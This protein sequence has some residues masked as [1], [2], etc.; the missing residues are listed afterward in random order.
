[1]DV[2]IL[3]PM[4]ISVR[5]PS[6][7]PTAGKP[8]QVLALLALRGDSLVTVPTLMEEI[9]GEQPPRSAA[10]TL[11]TYILQLRRFIGGELCS[12]SGVVAKDV[13]V[14][15]PGG[16]VLA[17]A[18][19][20]VDAAR[21]EDLA[22]RGRKA[23]A[24]GDDAAGSDLLG[25]ALALWRGPALVDIG[26]GPVLELEAMALEEARMVAL[27]QRIEADL[28]MG[29]HAELVVELIRLTRQHPMNENVHRL[30]MAAFAQCG[31]VFRAL[32]TY[33]VLRRTLREEL[34]IEP[35]DRIRRVHHAILSGGSVHEVGLVAAEVAA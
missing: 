15:R 28:R 9:W 20:F 17:V 6:T 32:E 11:Q 30:L 26:P 22:A 7:L 29:R 24:A 13:L 16:Y 12:E 35:S 34:G 21:F 10:T 25:R 14:T 23:C 18:P 1:V 4:E 31:N 8:R 19:G 3:G 2:K 5:G 27:E 33:Q